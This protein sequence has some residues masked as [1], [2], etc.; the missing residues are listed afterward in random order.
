MGFVFLYVHIVAVLS[1]LPVCV[2]V[3][4]VNSLHLNVMYS[5]NVGEHA[6]NYCPGSRTFLDM[7]LKPHWG[8]VRLVTPRACCMSMVLFLDRP[9]GIAA[10]GSFF[11]FVI[12]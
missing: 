6:G 9:V 12:L 1:V 5:S 2:R 4:H 7:I 11:M 3:R 8:F 10:R